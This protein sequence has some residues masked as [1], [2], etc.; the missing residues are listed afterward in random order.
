MGCQTTDQMWNQLITTAG[1]GSCSRLYMDFH[2]GDCE[3]GT[4]LGGCNEYFDVPEDERTSATWQHVAIAYDGTTLVG[5]RNGVDIAR[6]NPTTAPATC[7]T[8]SS[9]EGG[10]SFNIGAAHS[11]PS[12]H[13]GGAEPF[14]GQMDEV[15]IFGI[16]LTG[17]EIAAVYN[18]GIGINLMGV[19]PTTGTA[20][21][22]TV[23]ETDLT[24]LGFDVT[25]NASCNVGYNGAPTVTMCSADAE[26]YNLTGC[27]PNIC[28][29][30][31]SAAFDDSS[32]SEA[33]YDVFSVDT[34]DAAIAGYN[35]SA[36]VEFSL[37]ELE[38]NVSGITCLHGYHAI[39]E[40]YP[41]ASACGGD[42]ETYILSGCEID[43]CL[44]PTYAADA[45]MYD[46]SGVYWSWTGFF[47]A[48]VDLTRL[49]F[50]ATAVTCAEVSDARTLPHAPYFRV[51]QG[52]GRQRRHHN[53][54]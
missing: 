4:D 7:D 42:G 47:W 36:V 45:Y 1:G 44:H 37:T 19:P 51:A 16:G 41:A 26:L 11:N 35:L 2:G 31:G 9:T 13:P 34:S 53:P 28:V 29:R 10:Y 8:T 22:Y 21:G 15:A 27:H 49:G 48:S 54:W 24:H 6:H 5:Y 25:T 38:L 14:H 12:T 3:W 40:G 33:D 30:P 52:S 50:N 46:L 23:T 32:G 43:T 20:G 18:G 17:D 39:G